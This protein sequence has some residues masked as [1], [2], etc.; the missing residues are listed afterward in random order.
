[1][2]DYPCY[3][4]FESG[5]EFCVDQFDA[6]DMPPSGDA[7]DY[8]ASLV[9]K[10]YIQWQ[11]LK[12]GPERIA[13]VLH[14]Y[15]WDLGDDLSDDARNAERLVWLACCDIQADDEYRAARMDVNNQLA[16]ELDI[17]EY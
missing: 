11:L 2:V 3:A 16:R 17:D 6:F 10:P 15:G 9:T 14:R 8:I 4:Y 7:S 1:M 13:D 5:I 12:L